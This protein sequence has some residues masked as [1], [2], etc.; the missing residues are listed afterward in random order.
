LL[1]LTPAIDTLDDEELMTAYNY[2]VDEFAP[3][4]D[5]TTIETLM[6]LLG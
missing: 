4:D 3:E 6:G 1:S 2:L 5:P